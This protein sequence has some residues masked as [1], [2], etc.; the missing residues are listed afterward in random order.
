MPRV[1]WF[2]RLR[3]EADPKAYERWVQEVDYPGAKQIPS[4]I[5]YRVYR[6]QGPCV[7]AP[8]ENF[9]FDYVEVAQ[10]T[11][12]E[13]YLRDLEEHPAAQAI[14]AEI[15]RYVESVGSAWGTPVPK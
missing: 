4:L 14:I 13:A 2:S 11:D 9:N 3:P 5:S 15:G 8:A 12:M 6:I 1:V 7:G 10:V